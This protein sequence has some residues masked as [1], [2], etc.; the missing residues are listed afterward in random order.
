MEGLELEEGTMG[1][2]CWGWGPFKTGGYRRQKTK[3]GSVLKKEDRLNSKTSKSRP[4]TRPQDRPR[5]NLSDRACVFP[6]TYLLYWNGRRVFGGGG[7]K[8]FLDVSK[9]LFKYVVI[10]ARSV[11][12]PMTRKLPLVVSGT[13][14]DYL[15]HRPF[16]CLSL[17]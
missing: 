3:T 11:K 17:L 14:T 5:G 6:R 4:T 15:K 16:L 1:G 9:R 7:V 13:Q 2:G 8:R 12:R 10:S